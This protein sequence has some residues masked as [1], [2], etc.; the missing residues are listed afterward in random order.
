MKR[1]DCEVGLEIYRE[2]YIIMPTG[3]AMH[4]VVYIAIELLV[5]LCSVSN[6]GDG[7]VSNCGCRLR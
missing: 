6:E 4:D 1:N 7:K 3:S 2:V 5:S